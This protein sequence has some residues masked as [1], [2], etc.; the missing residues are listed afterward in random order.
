MR[1]NA[2]DQEKERDGK[3]NIFHELQWIMPEPEVFPNRL[4]F[5]I[6]IILKKYK[7][8]QDNILI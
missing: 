4:Y 7:S 6:A 5:K 8:F 2:R 1:M 3:Q